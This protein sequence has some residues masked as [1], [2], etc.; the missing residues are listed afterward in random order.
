VTLLLANV[1]FGSFASFWPC[2][3]DFR[4]SPISGQGL[5]R[6]A[7]LKGAFFGLMH[8]SKS[9]LYSITSPVGLVPQASDLPLAIGAEPRPPAHNR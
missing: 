6:S 8:H 4:S 7:C 1:C 5:S 9:T 3:D 2:A